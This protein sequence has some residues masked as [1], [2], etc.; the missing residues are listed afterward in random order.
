M[1]KKQFEDTLRSIAA[2]WAAKDY[3][4]AAS[5][6]ASDVK[7]GDPTSYTNN[8]REEL[9]RFFVEDEGY[10]QST[11]WHN[12]L[13]DEDQQLGAA[14]YTYQGTH[15]YHGFV[16]IKVSGD[17]IVRWREYQHISPLEWEEFVQATKF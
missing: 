4:L 10:D 8:G 14:E 9:L 13:F 7:Y 17:K 2:A 15:R 6:F 5:F 12:I 1:T 3:N 16:L 11:V